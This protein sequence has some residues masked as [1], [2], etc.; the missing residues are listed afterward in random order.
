MTYFSFFEFAI[1]FYD[2]FEAARSIITYVNEGVISSELYQT[3]LHDP[4][5]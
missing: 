2:S 4:N 5:H 1:L 3:R